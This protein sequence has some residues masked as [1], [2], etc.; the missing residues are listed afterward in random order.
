M[1]TSNDRFSF[2]VVLAH[3]HDSGYFGGTGAPDVEAWINLYEMESAYKWWDDSIM[4][5]NIIFYLKNTT[6]TWFET[7][8]MELTSWY[9]CEI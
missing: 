9:L 2:P 3:P 6:C 4:L 7:C 5:A 8:E 1:P